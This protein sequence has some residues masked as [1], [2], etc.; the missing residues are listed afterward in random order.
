MEPKGFGVSDLRFY[1]G[2]SNSVVLEDGRTKKF[3]PQYQAMGA[4]KEHPLAPGVKRIVVIE[5]RRL[6]RR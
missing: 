6:L 3:C 4:W 5:E 1:H 2:F